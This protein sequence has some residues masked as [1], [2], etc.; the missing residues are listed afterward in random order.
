VPPSM[1]WEGLEDKGF[2]SVSFHEAAADSP[3]LGYDPHCAPHI[4]T[5]NRLA[6]NGVS[7]GG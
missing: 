1:D 7:E 2:R 6:G 4:R 5:M 3:R